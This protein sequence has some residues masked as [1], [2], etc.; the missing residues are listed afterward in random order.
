MIKDKRL[1]YL[2]K[3]V[4][5]LFL[6]LGALYFENPQQ[7]RLYIL[8]VVFLF[9]L[10]TGFVKASFKKE[11]KLYIIFFILDVAFIYIM[12]YNSRLLINYFFHSFYI[13]ILLE[14]SLTLGFRNGI[15]I[16]LFTLFVSM[17][18]YVYLIYYKLNYSNVSQLSFFLMINILIIVVTGFAQHNKE[19]KEKKDIL[20]KELLDV[21]RQLKLYTQE[22]KRLSIVEERNRIA[23]DIHDTLGHKMTALIMQLQM[24]EHLIK[25]DSN[26]AEKLIADAVETG[27]DTMIGIREVVET[28]R[29]KDNANL[30]CEEIKNLINEFSEKTGI[31]IELQ[32]ENEQIIKNSNV[33]YIIYRILQE[34]ITNAVRHGKA[35]KININL[36]YSFKSISFFIKDNGVGA[37][38]ITEGY[39]IKGIRERVELYSGNVEFGSDDGFSIKGILYLE[40]NND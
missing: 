15:L 26:Q 8:V 5:S 22:I 2:L 34:T 30:S 37:E 24:A 28:L 39:G 18:K 16:G 9:Y 29:I 35:T 17:I 31:D 40:G 1:L 23:R 13:I 27:R 11:K 36:N 38:N 32:I 14:A 19:E 7:I 12:E 25:N 6:F 21:N 3:L 10:T 20:Y 33:N 4:V